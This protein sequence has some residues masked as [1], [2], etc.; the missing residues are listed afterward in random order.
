MLKLDKKGAKREREGDLL[1]LKSKSSGKFNINLCNKQT[2]THTSH[3]THSHLIRKWNFIYKQE[4]KKWIETH[5]HTE[6]EIIIKKQTYFL[7]KSHALFIYYVILL[8]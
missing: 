8:I 6:K 5:I 7:N 1:N 3:S 4:R 2:H